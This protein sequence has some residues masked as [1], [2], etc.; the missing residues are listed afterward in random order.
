M[1]FPPSVLLLDDGEL[2]DVRRLLEDLGVDFV[3]LRGASISDGLEP[4]RDLLLT[5]ARRAQ[6][7]PRGT[8]TEGGV[9]VRVVVAS[10]EAETLRER[11]RRDGVDFMVRR[12]V[13]SEALRLLVLRALYRGPEKRRA[14]RVP[15]GVP[16]ACRVDGSRAEAVLAELST[17]GCR[18]LMSQPRAVGSALTVT[19]PPEMDGEDPLVLPGKVLRIHADGPEPSVAL[20]FDPLDADREAALARALLRRAVVPCRADDERRVHPRRPF[21]ETVTALDQ[22]A[23]RALVGRDLSLGGMRVEPHPELKTGDELSIAIYGNADTEPAT[24]RVVVVRDDGPDGLGLRFEGVSPEV[25]RR[26][27]SLVTALP[28]IEPLAGGEAAAMGAV[29][30]RILPEGQADGLD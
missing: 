7:I 6:T 2:S 24:V 11:L 29:L 3:H 10:E 25:E 15:F 18:L 4:P 20:A 12:P 17:G 13:H 28:S 19:I 27:E 14:I 23:G 1:S 5:T 8:A 21:E 30:S 9:P 26:L 16:V 22:E